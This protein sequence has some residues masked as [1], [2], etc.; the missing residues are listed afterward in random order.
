MLFNSFTRREGKGQ[1]SY[2]S[3]AKNYEG[4][5]EINLLIDK[6]TQPDHRYYKPRITFEEFLIFQIM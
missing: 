3:L 4:V 2:N 5:K 6:S 1:L